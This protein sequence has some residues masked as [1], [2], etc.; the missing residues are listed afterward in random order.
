MSETLAALI[1]FVGFLILFSIIVQSAQ[2]AVKN[3]L[4]L[5]VGVWERFFINLYSGEFILI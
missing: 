3:I 5:R 2:E 4:K 1:A